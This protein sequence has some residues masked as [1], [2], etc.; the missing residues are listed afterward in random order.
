MKG[1]RPGRSAPNANRWDW[2]RR[3]LLHARDLLLEE[4]QDREAA[5]RMPKEDGGID[6]LDRAADA[7]L[8][9]ELLAELHKEEVALAEIE[10]AL[11][12][13]DGGT[14]GICEATGRPIARARLRALPWTRVVHPSHQISTRRPHSPGK[15]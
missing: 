7:T 4:H 10:A 2:H 14:Y 3:A 8:R 13:I 15:A 5:I 6:A 9:A 12:R 1:A 11:Q